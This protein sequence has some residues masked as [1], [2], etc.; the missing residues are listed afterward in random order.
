VGPSYGA[1]L[2]AV[3]TTTKNRRC[4]GK[5]RHGSKAAAYGQLDRLRRERAAVRLVIYAC[6][7]C[8]GFH[9]GH[10]PRRSRGTFKN[11]AT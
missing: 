8:G 5:R 4:T 2:V 3:T 1:A 11:P 6:P 10:R 7:H 9:V